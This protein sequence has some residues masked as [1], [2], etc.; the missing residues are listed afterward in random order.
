MGTADE[1]AAS[2][3][4][5]Y[6]DTVSRCP[7]TTHSLIIRLNS[8][9][10]EQQQMVT[11]AIWGGS[12]YRHTPH[13]QPL[14]ARPV[15]GTDYETTAAPK[16]LQA[17]DANCT[18]SLMSPLLILKIGVRVDVSHGLSTNAADLIQN[19]TFPLSRS[20]ADAYD[21][22]RTFNAPERGCSL[23]GN[24]KFSGLII[25]N[26]TNWLPRTCG[27]SGRSSGLCLCLRVSK[28]PKHNV[29]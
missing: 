13:P 12:R 14:G 5:L 23:W 1:L 20:S 25:C 28:C 17:T 27:S 22:K 6:R 21:S 11:R 26:E 4:F 24:V 16:K 9:R 10:V 2:S 18:I 3:L 29:R 8:L 15:R 7:N 19:E